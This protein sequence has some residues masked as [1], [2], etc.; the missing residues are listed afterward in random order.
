[1][2]IRDFF[3]KNT[4]D[5]KLQTPTEYL[6]DKLKSVDLSTLSK[7]Q[8]EN[9]LKF[10]NIKEYIKSYFPKRTCFTIAQPAMGDNLQKIEE[11]DETSLQ[12]SFLDNIK[13]LKRYV[14]DR[15]PKYI[16]NA[17]KKPLDGAGK[18]WSCFAI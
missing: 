4:K 9:Q 8:K 5:G 14:Y 10:N 12:K 15:K 18:S 13:A 3:L 17:S 1:M 2:C 7:N 6:E 16:C 11:L